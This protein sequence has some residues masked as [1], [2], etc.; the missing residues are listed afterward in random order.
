MHAD[1]RS[2]TLESTAGR[3]SDALHNV[4]FR[5]I[6]RLEAESLLDLGCGDGKFLRRVRKAKPWRL[7]GCDGYSHADDWPS[8]AIEFVQADLNRDLPIADGSFDLVSAIEVIEHLENPRHFTREIAR[9]LKPGG[10]A[11][12]STPNNESLTSLISLSLRGYFS[13]FAPACYPAHI[14]PILCL[15]LRR[16]LEEAGFEELE[17]HW[18]GSGRM[19]GTGR[20]WPDGFGGRRF[21]DNYFVLGRRR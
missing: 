17:V 7:V 11:L 4:A 14:T 3:S 12:L 16:A 8:H 5:L 6:D 21:S 18:S 2:R 19:P 9:L 15:D 20:H 13:A 10:R 1:L